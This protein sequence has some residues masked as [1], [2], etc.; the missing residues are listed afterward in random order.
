MDDA[1]VQKQVALETVAG[2][3]GQFFARKCNNERQEEAS[4]IF[5]FRHGNKLA[6]ANGGWKVFSG[7]LSTASESE[8]AQ[9][10]E[11]AAVT[12]TPDQWQ[13]FINMAIQIAAM[14]AAKGA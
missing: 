4:T 12:L 5:F 6:R 8:K 10:A 13:V 14:I 7:V 1:Q 9:A 3:A 2:L 11:A